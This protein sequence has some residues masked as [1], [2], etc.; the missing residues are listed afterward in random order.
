MEE[1]EVKVKRWSFCPTCKG[2]GD[3]LPNGCPTCNGTGRVF[4]L[5]LLMDIPKMVRHEYRQLQADFIQ[6][7]IDG[8]IKV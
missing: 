6:K 8:K 3:Y 7:Q 4:E 5:V 1:Q 2:R